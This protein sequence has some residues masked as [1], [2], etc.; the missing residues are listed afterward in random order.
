M[1]VLVARLRNAGLYRAEQ[2][3][4]SRYGIMVCT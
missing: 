3:Q 1:E 2:V 4:I